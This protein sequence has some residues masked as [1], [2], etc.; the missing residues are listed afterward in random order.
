VV[1]EPVGQPAIGGDEF[2]VPCDESEAPGRTFL[3]QA[4]KEWLKRGLQG[5][6]ATWKVVANQAMIMSLD[7]PPRNEV[8]KDQWD[9]YAAERA[10]IPV[11]AL[12]AHAEVRLADDAV[13]HLCR[14]AA[15]LDSMVTG[16]TQVVAQ[17]KRAV[18]DPTL[19]GA[20]VA[21]VMEPPFPA[22]SVGDSVSE[23]VALLAGDLQALMVT[24]DGRAAGIVTRADLLE[25]LAR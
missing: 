25:A 17:L 13:R 10:E 8:N 20:E 23:A 22:V 14:V 18:A 21:E 11:E 7:G 16:E 3:G 5:S 1:R 19:L 12:E 24:V 2:F 4:Q 6:R 9:G 15:G